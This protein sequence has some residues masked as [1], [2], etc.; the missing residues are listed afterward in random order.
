MV[1]N[2]LSPAEIERLTHV[3]EEAAEVV[4]AVT[5]IL[6]HG[7]TSTH[8]AFPEHNNREHL[9]REMG[10]LRGA[11]TLLVQAKEAH[12]WEY[13]KFAMDKLQRMQKYL[14]CQENIDLAV[15]VL[16]IHNSHG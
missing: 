14:H 1:G 11:F 3:A 5:K 7:W 6:R 8:P 15:E 16:D 9:V 12:V 13:Q 2:N 10:D 4:Q